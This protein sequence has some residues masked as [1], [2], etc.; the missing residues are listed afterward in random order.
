MRAVL[1]SRDL[2]F[3]SRV[4]EV[5][6]AHGG[7]VVVVKNEDAFRAVALDDQVTHGGVV[8]VDL[9]K[10]PVNL[11][12]IQQVVSSLPAGSWRCISF[13]SHVHVDTAQDAL[14]RELGEVMPRS[15]FVQVL[16]SLF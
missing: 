5:A 11:E 8:L 10:C 1:L 14:R 6:A 13:F 12:A 16:P 3:I 7:E 15:K 2:L 4:K 9:E